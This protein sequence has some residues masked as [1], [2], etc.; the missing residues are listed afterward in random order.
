M[1]CEQVNKNI[2]TINIDIVLRQLKGIMEIKY[3][4]V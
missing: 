4:L 2:D 1:L 3:L